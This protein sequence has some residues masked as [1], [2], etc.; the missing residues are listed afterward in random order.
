MA[1][2]AELAATVA[3]ATHPELAEL[4][5]YLKACRISYL[6]PS[7]SDTTAHA[8]VSEEAVD[9]IQDR[10][11]AEGKGRLELPVM[12][13]DGYGADIAELIALFVFRSPG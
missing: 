1:S 5:H 7:R 12:V 2:L 4:P 3:V 9:A 13:H 10:L 11:T 6:N 8:Q